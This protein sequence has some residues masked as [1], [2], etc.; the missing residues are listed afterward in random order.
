MTSN[1]AAASMAPV[2][3]RTRQLRLAGVL[4]RLDLLPK[5]QPI[6]AVHYTRALVAYVSASL[7][8]AA[9]LFAWLTRTHPVSDWLTLSAASAAV[10]L[11]ALFAV[12]MGLIIRTAWTPSVLVHLGVC[13]T[14]GPIGA[15]ATGLGEA[16]GVAVRSRNGWFRSAFNVADHALS[17]LA[18]WAVY[19][20]I[21]G[22]GHPPLGIIVAASLLAAMAHLAVNHALLV[23][24]IE[25]EAHPP[26]ARIVQR[27]LSRMPYSIGYGLSAWTLVY[28]YNMTGAVGFFALVVPVILLQGFLVLFARRVEAYDAQQAAHQKEREALLQQAVDASEAERRRIARDLHDGVVQNL[29]GMAFTLTA[30]ASEMKE[31]GDLNGN[32]ALL[33][34]LESSAEETRAAMKDLRTL[35]IEI[36]PPTLRREGLHAALLEV[37]R[38]IEGGGTQTKLALP[39]NMRLRQD[40]ASLVFRVA[41]EVL[42]NVAAHAEAK[43]VSVSLREVDKMAVLRITDD[44]KGFTAED[45]ARRR[46]EGHVGTNAIVEV[47]EEAGGTL[48]IHSQPGKG[49]RVTLKVPTE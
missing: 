28:M 19:M 1:A 13:F 16:L 46:A 48:D 26:F 42:R 14:F 18:A 49:T 11:M 3:A 8:L 38:T 22:R 32:A 36:A 35:I 17:G 34:L 12:R 29:A 2:E 27:W 20:T 21:T 24:V 31:K 47:A 40:R 44:G 45:V 37:L 25:I 6:E 33:E 4:A 23:G 43:H 39:S 5:P 10:F 41:Q 9:G 15:L 30:T 7:L